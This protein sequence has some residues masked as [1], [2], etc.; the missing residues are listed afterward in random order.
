MDEELNR[1]KEKPQSEFK[2]SKEVLKISHANVVE[3]PHNPMS[4]TVVYS[5]Q[6]WVGVLRVLRCFATDHHQQ[7]VI[8]RESLLLQVMREKQSLKQS[9]EG[10][11][12]VQWGLDSSN[13]H[14]FLQWIDP[15]VHGWIVRGSPNVPY[16]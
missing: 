9:R 13:H 6:W 2:C 14:E 8:R 1:S 12:I 7:V 5:H 10:Q 3:V 15:F 16:P 11:S 4:N